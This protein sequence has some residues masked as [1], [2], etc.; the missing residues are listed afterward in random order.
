M[1]I[2]KTYVPE[3]RNRVVYPYPLGLK[4]PGTDF[5]GRL[6]PSLPS[7]I[8]PHPAIIYGAGS[9]HTITR[10]AGGTRIET[11]TLRVVKPIE[12][13]FCQ[14]AQSILA[15]VDSGPQ[16]LVGRTVFVKIFDS[17]YVNPDDLLTL[18]MYKYINNG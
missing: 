15:Q 9:I 7:R 4:C 17:L 13:G 2:P 8:P 1:S 12:V 11:V 3:R 18:G 10:P 16:D 6:L 5:F 14:F